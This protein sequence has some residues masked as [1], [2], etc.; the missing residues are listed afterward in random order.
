[1]QNKLK[2]FGIVLGITAFIGINALP[3]ATAA[4]PPPNTGQALEIAPPLV[5]LNVNPG[6]KTTA[7]IL[8]RDVSN[9]PLNVTGQVN[10]F[11]ATG[12][13]GTPK[14][15]LDNNTNDP[16][17]MKAW[18]APIPTLQLV[19]KQIKTL[20]ITI[21]VPSDASPGGHYGVVRFTGTAPSINGT[22]G[23]TL[24]ASIGALML[25]TVSGNIHHSL[26]V[27]EF[28]VNHGGKT[29]SIFQSGPLNFVERITNSGNVH[30]QPT[31]QITVKDMFGR[32][33]ATLPVNQPPGNVLPGSTRKFSQKLDKSVIGSKHLFG[34]Y[35]ANL[36]MTYGTA[37]KQNLTATTTF[38]VIPLKTIAIVII[39]LVALFF[40]LRF[41]IRRYN[42]AVLNRANRRR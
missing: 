28:S 2:R 37:T 40:I 34:R 36:S 38:W 24:S 3:I 35:T 42:Q 12:E 14:V 19:P 22:N 41:A 7:Q 27:K 13:T 4:T 25:L 1:M 32:K 9:S 31:G 21:N 8:I 18:V 20:T 33:L 5:Y 6:Q 29:S 30:E 15:I 23:V 11:V 17:S 39:G 26:T 16:Y 10:D